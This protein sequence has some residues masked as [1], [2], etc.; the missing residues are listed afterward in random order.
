M[1]FAERRLTNPTTLSTV[2][3][4]VYTVPSQYTT[5]VKQV[6]VTNTTASPASF[7]LYIGSATSANAI[8]SNTTISANDSLI[9]N[10]S[11]VLSS[12]EILTASANANSAVNMTISGVENNGPLD[13]ANVYIADGA[14]TTSKLSNSSVTSEKIA[15]G[16]IVNADI[17]ASAAIDKTKISGTAITAADI[18]AKGDLFVGTADNTF[19]RLAVGTNG[20]A[21]VANSSTASGVNW[22]ETGGLTL[23]KEVALTSGGTANVTSV[24]S[25]T[26]RNYRVVANFTRDTASTGYLLMRIGGSATNHQMSG[27]YSTWNSPTRTGDNGNDGYVLLSSQGANSFT[28][29]VYGPNLAQYTYFTAVGAGTDYTSRMNVRV[30]DTTQY[31]SFTLVLNAGNFTGGSVQVYGYKVA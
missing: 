30:A 23:I 25:S 27:E 5:I 21:L 16:T 20:L 3:S 11:Q 22:A 31:T 1:P 9:I 26:Y 14:I 2:A 13:P 15:D 10:L 7:N 17:N 24:F 28:A 18:D 19:S 6:V 12:L 29:D 8:F 4:T